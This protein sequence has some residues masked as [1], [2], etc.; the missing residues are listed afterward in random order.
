M[1]ARIPHPQTRNPPPG[2]DTPQ[3]RHPPGTRPPPRAVHA[4]RY[5]QRA[6]DMHPTGMQS[7]ILYKNNVFRESWFPIFRTDKIPRLF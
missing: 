4:G 2:A 3:S 5:G 1:H 6:G 7:C